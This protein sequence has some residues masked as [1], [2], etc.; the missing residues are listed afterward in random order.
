MEGRERQWEEG[1][2]GRR[3]RGMECLPMRIV[4]IISPHAHTQHIN[5]GL[6]PPSCPEEWGSYSKI[7]QKRQ[8]LEQLIRSLGERDRKSVVYWKEC[9]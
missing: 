2:E 1:R 8:D 3:G 4:V 6:P 5:R 7:Q 9:R